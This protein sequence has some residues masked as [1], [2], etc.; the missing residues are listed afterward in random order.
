[1]ENT[2]STL[3]PE[4]NRSFN[5]RELSQLDFRYDE[6]PLIVGRIHVGMF[7]GSGR[8]TIGRGVV[9]NSAFEA[10]PVGGTRTALVFKSSQGKDPGGIIEIGDYTG[11]SNAMIA[12]MERVC[13]GTHVNIG[14][15]AKI[16][17]TDFHSIDLTERI[18]DVNVPHRPVFI[19]DGAFIGTNAII[20]KGVTVGKA[21]V[22]AAGAVVVKSVPPGEI[23]GGN[24]AKCIRK[25][26]S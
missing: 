6:F 16:M 1:M 24:P 20:L 18:D 21:S 8:L 10:N 11:I 26:E 22:I 15:G 4:A 9:I 19:D 3:D 14:A 12:S 13:I 23:W 25:I 17:D 5:E 2:S 7:A